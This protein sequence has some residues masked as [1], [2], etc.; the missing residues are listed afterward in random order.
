[1]YGKASK[2][3]TSQKTCQS[4]ILSMLSGIKAAIMQSLFNSTFSVFIP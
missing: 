2:S 3:G 4:K 1:M